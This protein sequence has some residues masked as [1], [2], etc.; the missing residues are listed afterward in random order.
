MTQAPRP[1]PL[2]DTFF[3]KEDTI[4]LRTWKLWIS[5][6]S[7]MLALAVLV[8]GCAP[9][10][11]PTPT[12]TKA[13][14]PATPTTA[15]PKA[16][17]TKPAEKPAEKAATTPTSAPAAKPTGKPIKIG[18]ITP[19]TGRVAG[20]GARQKIAVQLA[21]EDVNSRGGINGSPL[22][23]VMVDDQADPRQAVTLVRRL[24]I[25]DKVP[26]ILGPLTTGA[27]EVAA[28]LANEL[29]VP[30]ATA[31]SSKEG[32]TDQNRPWIFRFAGLDRTYTTKG[33][34][35]YKKVYPNVKRMVITGDTKESVNENIVK[36]IYPKA[37]KDAGFEVIDTVPFETGTTDFSAIIT[38]IKG[39]N[40]DGIAYSSLTPEALGFAKE[41]QKQGVKAPVM[42]SSQN[43]S[44]PEITLGKD[45]LEG[46]VAPGNF[47]EDTQDPV[48]RG[49]VERFV[50]AGAADPA[51]GQPAYVAFWGQAYDAVMA[52]AEVM[53]KANIAPDTD[54]QKAREA[55]RDGLQNLRGFKGLA[56][57]ISMQPNGDITLN[58]MAFVAKNGKWTLI[59]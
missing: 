36:N 23:V 54:L 53:R 40:P 12:P 47:D 14:P 21:L 42:A 56:R 37:L 24:A 22:E 20:Y 39:L 19:L 46:W 29:K 13:A 3:G 31:T 11:A 27:F 59:K 51:V 30:L 38:K 50:K 17:A 4:N 44:G 57:D 45:V 41:L 25:E 55:I 58:T 48:A 5:F 26:F 43:Y 2:G 18:F 15:A 32:I 1:L 49:V 28:P 35:G 52:T 10:A 8:A 7:A 9:A 6:V 33:I 34:E 16:E